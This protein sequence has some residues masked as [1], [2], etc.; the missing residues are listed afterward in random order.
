MRIKYSSN[1]PTTKPKKESI[2]VILKIIDIQPRAPES[3][4]TSHKT[5]SIKLPNAEIKKTK[6]LRVETS[7]IKF[8]P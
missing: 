4:P 3:N 1:I 5:I 2:K 7:L 8:L 6:K